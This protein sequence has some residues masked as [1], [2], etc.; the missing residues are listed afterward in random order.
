MDGDTREQLLLEL[1]ASQQEVVRLLES[2][3][4]IQDWQPEPVEWSFRYIAAHLATVEQKCHL[5]RVMRI[6]SGEGPHF[7]H[8]STIA[9]N[10]S[11]VDLRDSLRKWVSTR[12]QLIDFVSHLSDRE[13]RFTGFHEA[14]GPMTVLDAL[15]EILD[16][17]QGNLRH[18]FQLII[19]YQ[20]DHENHEKAE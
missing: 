15:Q 14:V 10:F 6:A 19:D 9:S 20:E 18:V 3:A 16:Q 17:D 8:Y 1:E 4:D 2:V 12:H 11:E 5:R 7:S 13:L